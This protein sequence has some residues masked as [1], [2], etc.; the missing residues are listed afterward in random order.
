MRKL[1]SLT[2]GAA[3]CALAGAA[4]AQDT[5]VINSFGGAYEEAHRRLVIEPFEQMYNVKIEVVTAYSADALAQLRAQADSP[6]FDVIHFSGGQEITAAKEGLLVP[7]APDQLTNY[8]DMYPFAVAGIE[9]GQGP[10]YS[11]AALGLLYNTEELAAAPTSWE[12]LFDPALAGGVAIADISNTYG[13]L[14]LLMLNQVRGGD[15]ADIQ[16]GLDAVTQ[17]LDNDTVIVTASPEMQQAFATGGTVLAAYAQ[18]YAHTLKEAGLPVEFVQPSEGVPAIFITAN[19]VAGRPHTD[20]AI[21]FVDFSLRA[22][23]QAGW[24]EELRYSPTN[25]TVE[26]APEIAGSVLYGE[27]AIQGLIRF[28]AETVNDSRPAWTDAWNRTIAR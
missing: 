14:T 11:I 23:A 13:L 20:L 4:A 27:E 28:D 7:I 26:L 18:D 12:A 10:V 25:A 19:V 17:L 21:K 15:L 2:I 22:E 9:Q 8:G 1:N 16:P 24:A 5:L 6:Q 3:L